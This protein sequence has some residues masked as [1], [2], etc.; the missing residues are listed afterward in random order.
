MTKI[1]SCSIC[2]YFK[3]ETGGDGWNEPRETEES[4][5]KRQWEFEEP[6]PSPVT[7]C[8]LF[9]FAVPYEPIDFDAL[10]DIEEF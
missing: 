9:D 6:S 1:L 8:K 3:S 5:E 10:L 7:T 4:C 2:Q